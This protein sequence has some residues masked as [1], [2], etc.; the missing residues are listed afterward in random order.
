[1]IMVISK[2]LFRDLE[3]NRESPGKKMNNEFYERLT[4]SNSKSPKKVVIEVKPGI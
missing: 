3:I 1:M 4:I 2:Q